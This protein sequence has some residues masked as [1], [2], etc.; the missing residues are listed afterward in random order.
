MW[1]M[2]AIMLLTQN[3]KF[4]PNPNYF[5]HQ[6]CLKC[7]LYFPNFFKSKDK[8]LQQKKNLPFFHHIK[9]KIL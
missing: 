1:V 6:I 7:N 5:I 8:F 3:K 2:W 9:K 4:H